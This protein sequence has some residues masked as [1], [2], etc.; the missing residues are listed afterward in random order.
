MIF[1]RCPYFKCCCGFCNCTDCVKNVT[2]SDFIVVVSPGVKCFS[3]RKISPQRLAALSKRIWSES[4]FKILCEDS[5]YIFM[6]TMVVDKLR[7]Q[8]SLKGKQN[9]RV[10]C[11]E[12]L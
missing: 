12:F 3:K 1:C 11:Y 4:C 9:F 10:V 7:Y 6:L 5:N 8:Q 2:A